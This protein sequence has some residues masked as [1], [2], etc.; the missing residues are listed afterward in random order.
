MDFGLNRTYMYI[1]SRHMTESSICTVLALYTY[2]G[3][4]TWIVRF[5]AYVG[6]SRGRRRGHPP[7]KKI[8]HDRLKKSCDSCRHRVTQC[9]DVMYSPP[10]KIIFRALVYKNSSAFDWATV[11]LECQTGQAYWRSDRSATPHDATDQRQTDLI[12][13]TVQKQ[14]LRWAGECTKIRISKPNNL[15]FSPPLFFRLRRN[16]N[17]GSV[18][19]HKWR[20]YQ[21]RERESQYNETKG[22]RGGF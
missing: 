17:P 20:Q 1:N 21:K 13:I 9:F 4:Y 6:R 2:Y 12:R 7:N 22:P 18:P 16:P 3:N 10:G 5:F 11:S 15:K 14:T 8:T 19:G